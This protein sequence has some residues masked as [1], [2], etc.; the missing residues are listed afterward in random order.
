MFK[1][2]KEVQYTKREESRRKRHK[3]WTWKLRNAPACIDL[4]RLGKGL[5]SG[6][7]FK[8]IS[9]EKEMATHSSILAWKIPWTKEPGR[10]LSMGV[11]KN[12][13][14]LSDF[15]LHFILAL[16]HTFSSVYLCIPPDLNVRKLVEVRK[17]LCVSLQSLIYWIISIFLFCLHM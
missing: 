9:M 3:K 8:A 2:L 5:N 10:L 17:I 12:R 16:S 6:E 13:T 15:T 11:E 7:T 14:R 1:E 4:E